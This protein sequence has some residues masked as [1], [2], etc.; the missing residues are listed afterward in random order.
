[1]KR[2]SIELVVGLFMIA[3]FLAFFYLAVKMGDLSLFGNDRYTVQAR[4]TN[5]SGLKEGAYV[6]MAGVRVGKVA[7]IQF[8]PEGYESILVLSIPR[9]VKL[10]EDTIASVRTAGIIGDKYIKLA[11]GGLDDYIEEGGEII[12][13]ESSLDIEELISKYM[14]ESSGKDKEEG[15]EDK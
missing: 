11:P 9:T 5:T 10:Q 8:D 12:E 2:F 13:T 1:M 6:E 14:F 7:S 4:F 15:K 3:G